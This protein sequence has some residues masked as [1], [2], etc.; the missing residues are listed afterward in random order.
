MRSGPD[1]EPIVSDAVLS[2]DGL[3]RLIID[4]LGLEGIT[5]EMIGDDDPLFG[6]DLDLDSVDA[7][8]IVVA[9]EREFGVK[10]RSQE[11]DPAVFANVANLLAYVRTQVERDRDVAG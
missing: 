1:G 11:V 4:S 5:P 9:L 2:S 7:L 10:I 3:K 8:E 6:G